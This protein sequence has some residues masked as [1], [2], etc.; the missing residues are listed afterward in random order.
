MM[1]ILL[2]A[3]FGVSAQ[4]S[5][6]ATLSHEGQITSFYSASAFKDA[7]AA[8]QDGDVITL[9]DGLFESVENGIDKIL[10]VRGAGMMPD[11]NPTIITG[12]MSI[13]YGPKENIAG[14]FTAE[15]IMFNGD[16]T[17]G[18]SF[19]TVS[20]D[21]V[22]FVK[23]WFSHLNLEVAQNFTS[24]H[25]IYIYLKTNGLS[26]SYFSNSYLGIDNGIEHANFNNCVVMKFGVD[27]INSSSLKNCIVVDSD[28]GSRSSINSNTLVSNC[29]YIGSSQTPFKNSFSTTNVVKNDIKTEDILTEDGHTD[30]KLKPEIAETWLGDDGTQVGMHGGAIPFDPTPTNPQITKFNVANKT[31]ADGKLSVE[32][33]VKAD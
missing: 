11:S 32:I 33:E 16:I 25:C 23:C 9:S 30:W 10:T 8:A 26:N 5:Q 6:V 24:L 22:R 14:G 21:D 2:T 20:A 7:Y 27:K 4:N 13:G 17:I 3:V 19:Y 28:S 18:S 31:T 1:A 12:N 29:Y 15:G